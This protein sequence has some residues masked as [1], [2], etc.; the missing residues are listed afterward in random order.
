MLMYLL[1]YITG[2]YSSI[3]YYD[4]IFIPSEIN[5]HLDK[6]QNEN[7][8]MSVQLQSIKNK[9]ENLITYELRYNRRRA[10]P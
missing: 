9:L 10:S 2:F 5:L 3:W 6:I 1:T 4:Y 8:E 7:K